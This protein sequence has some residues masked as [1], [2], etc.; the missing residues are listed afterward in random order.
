[1]GYFFSCQVLFAYFLFYV[2]YPCDKQGSSNRVLNF[3]PRKQL[4]PLDSS[5]LISHLFHFVFKLLAV[6]GQFSLEVTNVWDGKGPG[7]ESDLDFFFQ[8]GNILFKK[9]AGQ[10]FVCLSVFSLVVTFWDF[11]STFVFSAM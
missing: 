1:M 8:T 11:F 5:G 7:F 3:F 2:I 6:P 10:L 4:C 9:I